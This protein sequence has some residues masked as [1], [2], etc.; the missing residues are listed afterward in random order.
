MKITKDNY[1]EIVPEKDQRLIAALLVDIG[2]INEK[3]DGDVELHISIQDWHNEYSCERT[4]PC[5]DYYGYYTI[6]TTNGDTIGDEMD[7]ETLD[8][9]MFIISDFLDYVIKLKNKDKK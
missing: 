6:C 9:A 5:P 2:D 1:K 3:L 8:N 7:I 4:D